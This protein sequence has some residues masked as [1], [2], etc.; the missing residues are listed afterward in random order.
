LPSNSG[1]NPEVQISAG[2]QVSAAGC[3]LAVQ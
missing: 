1:T 2:D 3:N